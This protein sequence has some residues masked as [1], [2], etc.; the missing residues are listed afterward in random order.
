MERGIIEF[1]WVFHKA[2]ERLFGNGY[3]VEFGNGGF[4]GNVDCTVTEQKLLDQIVEWNKGQRV[5]VYGI[6]DDVTM[7]DL[8]LKQ[9]KIEAR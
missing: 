8:Q 4:T 7:G 5:H 1:T 2:S 6:I 3:R 9:C